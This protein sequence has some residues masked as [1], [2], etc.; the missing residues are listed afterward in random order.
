LASPLILASASPR[1]KD[2]L[3]AAGF[4][5]SVEASNI[6]EVKGE[7]ESPEAY[8]LRLALEKS[9]DVAASNTK[10]IVIGADTIVANV[11]EILEKP[12]D[13]AH[14]LEMLRSLS[15]GK[16]LVHTAFA[17]TCLKTSLSISKVVTTEVFFRDLS[18][19]E[20]EHY[21]SSDEPFD[22]AGSYGIQGFASCFVEKIQGSYSNVVGLP[23]AEIVFELENLGVSRFIEKI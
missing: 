23:L 11:T 16:H 1:R 8:C 3:Q 17:I 2:L 14:A 12:A 4:S 5:F 6:E 18:E 20:L 13:K 10:A 15:G 9:R 19:I 21:V 7:L 22:K